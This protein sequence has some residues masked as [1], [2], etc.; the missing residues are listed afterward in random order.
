[1]G[2]LQN[3]V[4]E[5]NCMK[6]FGAPGTGTQPALNY[7]SKYIFKDGIHDDC[8]SDCPLQSK[9]GS[10][11]FKGDIMCRQGYFLMCDTS[12]HGQYITDG[13]GHTYYCDDNNNF[14]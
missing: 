9:S 11:R 13:S 14:V 5:P 10:Y 3:T 6:F 12:M 1:G 2:I 8:C 7:F 4:E